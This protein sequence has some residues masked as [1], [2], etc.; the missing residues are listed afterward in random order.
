MADEE[1]A[2]VLGGEVDKDAPAPAPEEKKEETTTAVLVEQK[3]SE[4]L[5][6]PA[7]EPA[8]AYIPTK[9]EVETVVDQKP[10]KAKKK[11]KGVLKTILIVLLSLIFIIVV[12]GAIGFFMITN[13][14]MP[15]AP[16]TKAD[17][18]DVVS[19]L[20]SDL[21]DKNDEGN[22]RLTISTNDMNYIYGKIEPQIQAALSQSDIGLELKE[23]YIVLADSKATY[24][25]RLNYKGINVPVRVFLKVKFAEPNNIVI[26]CDK[27]QLGKLT[28]PDKIINL[29]LGQVQMPDGLAFDANTGE[30]AYNVDG[31]NK[32][33]VDELEKM[34]AANKIENLINSVFS[35]FGGSYNFADTINI[36]VG[37]A[38]I[39]DNELVL[40]V[41][42]IIGK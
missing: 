11:R 26:T 38:R 4:T 2:I 31:L 6:K 3:E 9:K 5:A 34:E 24:Y 28:I 17:G 39:I 19:G 1:K 36:Q 14:D 22:S 32:M 12:L 30:L 37:D 8:Q 40:T 13:D 42:N 27:A 33:L 21:F 35:I 41:K 15:A 23:S 29:V 20:V 16:T 25:A 18:V 7:E 10:E